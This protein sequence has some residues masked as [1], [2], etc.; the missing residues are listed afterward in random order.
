[1]KVANLVKTLRF[2]P[3]LELTEIRDAPWHDRSLG[4]EIESILEASQMQKMLSGFDKRL[5]EFGMSSGTQ[6]DHSTG[7]SGIESVALMH[8]L[9]SQSYGRKIFQ[10]RVAFSGFT[11]AR[12][13]SCFAKLSPRG[14]GSKSIA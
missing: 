7:F 1:M 9:R 3:E 14:K 2:G 10:I 11:D 6:E 8:E 12:Q 4:T 13:T 5:A